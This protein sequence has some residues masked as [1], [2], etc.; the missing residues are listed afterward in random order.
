MS[1]CGSEAK[2]LRAKKRREFFFNLK[3]KIFLSYTQSI[4][5]VDKRKFRS[6]VNEVWTPECLVSMMAVTEVA[7][8]AFYCYSR[9]CVNLHAELCYK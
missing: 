8:V 9:Q 4:A 2:D 1:S 6:F 5:V 3:L 7:A